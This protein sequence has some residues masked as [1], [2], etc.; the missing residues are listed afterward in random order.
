MVVVAVV[1]A[2]AGYQAIHGHARLGQFVAFLAALMAASQ[3]L[4][5][6]ANLQTVFTEGLT[7]AEPVDAGH[8]RQGRGGGRARRPSAAAHPRPYPLPGRGFRLRPRR[9]GAAGH[10]PG[11]AARGD[12]GP[13]RPVRRRQVD[14]VE[15]DLALLRRHRRA[16]EPRRGGRARRHPGLAAKPHRAGHPGALPVRR[17]ACAPTS[18]TPG[19]RPRARRSRPPPAPP[20]PTSSS[21]PCPQGYDDGGGRGGGAAVR[22][23]ASAYRHRP[24]FPEGRAHP[25]AGR[26]YQRAR[27]RER[28]QGAGGV[29]AVDGRPHHPADRPSPV[30][31]ARRRP[32]LC[33]RRRPGGRGRRPRRPR[34]PRAASTP[35]WREPRRW[36][37]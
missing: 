35:D 20:P 21:P 2:Y 27:Y 34:P 24:R 3:A 10:G 9:A 28:G 29:G 1:I 22:R 30:H 11:G 25:A 8:G 7:A 31:R 36:T 33:H 18:P 5:Q 4:R 23:P 14:G 26:G 12:G 19:P 16:S 37:W 15:P 6:V 17:H 13:C 32:H